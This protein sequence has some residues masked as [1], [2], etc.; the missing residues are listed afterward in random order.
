MSPI[1]LRDAR[2]AAKNTAVTMNHMAAVMDDDLR[3]RKKM[4]REAKKMHDEPE[5]DEWKKEGDGDDGK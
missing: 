4:W 1:S 3:H 2:C 5:G